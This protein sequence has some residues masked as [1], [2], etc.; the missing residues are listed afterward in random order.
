[1]LYLGE[2]RCRE[3]AATNYQL[4]ITTN[5]SEYTKKM[6]E[7]L[8]V[9]EEAQTYPVETH[10]TSHPRVQSTAAGSIVG[11]WFRTLIFT[12]SNLIIILV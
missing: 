5:D 2:I 8:L 11:C 6:I 1:M 3:T 12:P 4:D 10:P 9:G 7:Q